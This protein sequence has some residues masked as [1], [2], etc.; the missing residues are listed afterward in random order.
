MVRFRDGSVPHSV[1]SFGT[2]LI[3]VRYLPYIRSVPHW[4]SSVP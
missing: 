4:N 1:V 3:F 2:F